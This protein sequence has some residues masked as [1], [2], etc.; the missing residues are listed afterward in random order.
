MF[1]FIPRGKGCAVEVHTHRGDRG[2]LYWRGV[3]HNLSGVGW[4]ACS[5]PDDLSGVTT[6]IHRTNVERMKPGQLY[7]IKQP[8]RGDCYA[9]AKLEGN[10][11]IRVQILGWREGPTLPQ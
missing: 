1:R 9:T 2:A 4:A 5:R 7:K 3:G 6:K 8:F 11:G 10:G